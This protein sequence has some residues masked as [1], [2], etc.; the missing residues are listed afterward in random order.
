MGS[1]SNTSSRYL[2]VLQCEKF[3]T[4]QLACLVQ[5]SN[6]DKLELAA[7]SDIDTAVVSVPFIFHP[8]HWKQLIDVYT[9][10]MMLD[11]VKSREGEC[12]DPLEDMACAPAILCIEQQRWAATAVQQH[13]PANHL[14]RSYSYAPKHAGLCASLPAC[15]VLT[16]CG[17]YE[18]TM[19]VLIML[20]D[21]THANTDVMVAA[22]KANM[23]A[24]AALQQAPLQ[25]CLRNHLC[26]GP[27]APSD[28]KGP[29][30]QIY[31]LKGMPVKSTLLGK[32]AL[33]QI[34]QIAAVWPAWCIDTSD[35]ND[36]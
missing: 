4:L 14:C 30:D 7:S 9:S 17:G 1:A 26:T 6:S 20:G 3:G 5:K 33:K 15:S 36:A 25:S 19:G 34:L 16:C 28:P 29:A 22:S 8:G 12:Q 10:P 23:T 13:H 24:M 27:E 2:L 31:R 21:V 11:L 18:I 32:G 35:A